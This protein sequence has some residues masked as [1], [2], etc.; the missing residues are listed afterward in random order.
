M[1]IR[2]P[3]PVVGQPNYRVMRMRLKAAGND[4]SPER[5]LDLLRQLQCHRI[6]LSDAR[7]VIGLPS[8]SAEQAEL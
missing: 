5:A 4:Y 8:V 1:C 7:T 3:A 6:H 2:S